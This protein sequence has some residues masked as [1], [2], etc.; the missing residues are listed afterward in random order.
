M[1]TPK[2]KHDCST[3]IFLD[4][5][6]LNNHPVDVYV[7]DNGGLSPTIVVRVDDKPE[8]YA[9]VNFILLEHMAEVHRNLPTNALALR[10]APHAKETIELHRKL[11]AKLASKDLVWF[12]GRAEEVI[13]ASETYVKITSCRNEAGYLTV[14]FNH[15]KLI[16]R[17]E[18]RLDLE[19]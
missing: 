5:D 8:Q 4:N 11:T 14:G 2:Y 13:E 6:V 17:K 15:V 9:T 10:H 12:E 7:C 19:D 16:C 18:D 1:A 3:C